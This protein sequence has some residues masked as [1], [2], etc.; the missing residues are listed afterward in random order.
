MKIR[1]MDRIIGDTVDSEERVN[2]GP[3]VRP[4]SR[5]QME[6]EKGQGND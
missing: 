6:N 1:S 5:T 4:T 3:W 2:D